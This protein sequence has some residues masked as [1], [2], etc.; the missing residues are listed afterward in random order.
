M[1]S[2]RLRRRQTRSVVSQTL[3]GLPVRQSL[4]GRPVR[5]SL[6]GIHEDYAA[7]S[8]EQQELYKSKYFDFFKPWKSNRWPEVRRTVTLS[9]LYSHLKAIKPNM[10]MTQEVRSLKL[11]AT[12]LVCTTVACSHS[13]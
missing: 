5:Q 9:T 7:L 1:L 2:P 3:N 13:F 10:D 11:A 6:E 4:D 8:A 12:V